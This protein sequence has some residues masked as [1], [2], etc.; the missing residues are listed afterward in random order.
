MLRLHSTSSD[1]GKNKESDYRIIEISGYI[2]ALTTTPKHIWLLD[3]CPTES[4]RDI[5][6]G[7]RFIQTLMSIKAQHRHGTQERL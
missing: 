1:F 3:L 2:R 6:C 5:F 4:S 7:S